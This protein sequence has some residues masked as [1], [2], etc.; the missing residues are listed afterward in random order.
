MNSSDPNFFGTRLKL[1]RKM[2]GM[3]LQDLSDVLENIVT[4]QSLNKY[5]QGLMNPTSGV[6][7]AM[8]KALNVKPDYF[9]KKDL[10]E[11]GEISFRKRASLSKKTTWRDSLKLKTYWV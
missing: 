7:L 2:A 3:S 1:A 9:L 8:A 10:L 11:F 4:K 5:E 6:L